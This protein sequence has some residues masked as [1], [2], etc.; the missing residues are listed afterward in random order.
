LRQ[1]TRRA[2]R[3]VVHGRIIGAPAAARRCTRAARLQRRL[4]DVHAVTQHFAVKADTH[5]KAGA[6]LTGE[7][8]DLTFL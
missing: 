6:M 1:L 2:G 7:E 4:R 3:H 8:V 5:T